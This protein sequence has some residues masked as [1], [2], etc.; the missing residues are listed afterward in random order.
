MVCIQQLE[1]LCPWSTWHTWVSAPTGWVFKKF[2]KLILKHQ[3]LQDAAKFTSMQQARH[4]QLPVSHPHIQAAGCNGIW[5]G[6]SRDQQLCLNSFCSCQGV[7]CNSPMDV[8]YHQCDQHLLQWKLLS[9]I[10]HQICSDISENHLL[11]TSNSKTTAWQTLM[12]ICNP[13]NFL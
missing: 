10:I 13:D 3:I 2:L 7:C 8:V 12:G 4:W 9:Y 1:I 5:G 11:N 6:E